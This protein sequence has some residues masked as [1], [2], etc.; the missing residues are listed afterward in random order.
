MILISNNDI[1]D[2]T[3]NLALEE[4]CV[5]NLNFEKDN[6][7]LFYINEPSIII[8]KHQCTMEE[9]NYE[10][11]KANNIH[12]V[13]RI[14]GG[15]AVYHDK[16][17]LNFSFLSKHTDDSIHNFEKFTK[18]V[19][20]TLVEMGVNAEM[21]GRNDIVVDGRKIS[22]N[23]QFTNMKSMFSHG[24]LLFDSHLEDVVQALNVKTDKIESKGIKSIRSRVA[25]ITEFLKEPM[26][27]IQFREKIIQSI[28]RGLPKIPIYRLSE[29]HWGE[30]KKLANEKYR[31]WEWNFGRSPEFNIQKTNRFAFGQIDAR[32]QVKDGI[33]IDVKFYGDFLGHGDTEEIE[34]RL[35]GKK[36]KEEEITPVLKLF[37]L[38]LYFG[39]ITPEEFAKFLIS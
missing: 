8:G 33:I 1:N 27:V 17:N 16:G 2:P 10:Y 18:P 21:T 9:I 24:T 36:Y 3:I 32:L 6:Y 23:A 39:T 12:V 4:Y 25:N 30:V 20:D 13:R 37:D 28:F 35:T 19:R 5:R 29:E 22:G 15:G 31:T 38:N 26:S 11:V 7:L 34:K 14:S